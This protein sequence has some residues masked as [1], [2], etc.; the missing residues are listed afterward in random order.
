M[1]VEIDPFPVSALQDRYAI[2][3]QAVYN[4][5]EALDI[6]PFKQGNKS[7][8]H[9]TD[10]ELL[11]QL[12]QHIKDGGKMDDFL[13]PSL[14]DTMDTP[15]GQVDI[16]FSPLDRV[17]TS[18]L[19]TGQSETAVG[20]LIALVEAIARHLKP[21]D[22]LQ[23]LKALEEA[24]KAGWILSSTEVENLIGCK[25]KLKEGEQQF[26]RGSFGFVKSGRV[27]NQSGWRVERLD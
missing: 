1:V 22:P 16:T 3:K 6:K 24:A 12:H 26:V 20:E 21:S 9:A 11:D 4:R 19:T 27:G 15:T 18:S 13:S 23:H 17:D 8:I 5:L 14:L 2:G 10:V 7:Y 25:P